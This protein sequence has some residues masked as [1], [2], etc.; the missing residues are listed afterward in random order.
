MNKR[1]ELRELKDYGDARGAMCV[2]E[3][4]RELPF[5]IQRFF[6]N[7]HS[8]GAESRGNHANIRSR[9]AFV[10]LSGSC[11]VEVDD[12]TH[13]ET[14]ALDDPHRMLCIDRMTWKVMRNFSAD[15]VL[16]VISDCPYDDSEYIRDYS[17][18]LELT[19]QQEGN[20]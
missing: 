4:N 8:N 9:F 6:Y 15:N 3:A 2:V 13:R 16:L 18:F 17:R 12:G 7:F 14:F 5:D 19:R 11:T 20:V 1:F 10:S